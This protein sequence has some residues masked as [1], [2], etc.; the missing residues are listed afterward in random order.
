[1]TGARSQRILIQMT[2]QHYRHFHA[3]HESF[4]TVSRH[5]LT[6]EKHNQRFVLLIS[7]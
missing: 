4:G 5:V 3:H 7:C 2:E 1:M 6:A